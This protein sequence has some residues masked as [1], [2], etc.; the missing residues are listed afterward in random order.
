MKFRSFSRS[1]PSRESS[2]SR[3]DGLAN[4]AGKPLGLSL[5]KFSLYMA[6]NS[7][8]DF[9]AKQGHA[10]IL[11]E[12]NEM[13]SSP[14]STLHRSL[15]LVS[16]PGE[17]QPALPRMQWPTIDAC[18]LLSYS[19]VPLLAFTEHLRA[20]NLQASPTLFYTTARTT[21]PTMMM[22][23]TGTPSLPHATLLGALMTKQEQIE[24][25]PRVNLPHECTQLHGKIPQNQQHLTIL[26][27]GGVSGERNA[28]RL[29]PITS[30]PEPL[31]V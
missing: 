20:I 21:Q 4:N 23:I 14:I 6:H 13:P 30:S 18:W 10:L 2:S 17:S 25:I 28:V 31:D 16:S 5:S 7:R 1:P 3:K 12:E 9:P 11:D 27:E 24:Q 15:P 19:Q 26:Y 22:P 29:T 8:R